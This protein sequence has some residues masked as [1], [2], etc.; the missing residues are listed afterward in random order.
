[1]AQRFDDRRLELEGEPF[2]I[3]E[4]VWL[5]PSPAQGFAA[6]SASGNGV[7]A[8]RTLP[9]ATT[10][11]VWFDRRGNRLGAV[12][13]PAN[14]S[15]PALSTDEKKLA[16]TRIDSHMGTR[17]LW[18]LIW[19]AGRLLGSPLIRLKKQIPHGHLTE[20]RSPSAPTKKGFWTSIRKRLRVT[21]MPSLSWNLVS[22]S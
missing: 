7:V 10:E 15:V 11:L 20:T 21:A 2:P 17:D 12:G 1:M 13:A 22:P 18:R 4:Q 5:P 6:F 16:V 3:A 14:Y 19:L 8:Y 9:A